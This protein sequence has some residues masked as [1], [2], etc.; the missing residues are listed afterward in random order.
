MGEDVKTIQTAKRQRTGTERLQQKLVKVP[1]GKRLNYD[2]DEIVVY[3][4]KGREVE[5]DIYDN[6]VYKGEDMR[7][8]ER[9]GN[10]DLRHGYKMVVRK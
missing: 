5:H 1:K 6:S 7:W 8:N 2:D 9:D 10:Y 4:D 3:D